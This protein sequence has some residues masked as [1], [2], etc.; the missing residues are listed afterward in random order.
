MHAGAQMLLMML[1]H[2]TRLLRLGLVAG[3][4]RFIVA[5]EYFNLGG[6][7]E[8]SLLKIEKSTLCSPEAAHPS[9]CGKL[10]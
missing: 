10:P 5:S 3:E 9:A 1:K 7:T 4:Q 6:H 2:L 8:V